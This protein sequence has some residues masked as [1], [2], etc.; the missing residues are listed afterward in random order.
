MDNDICKEIICKGERLIL[1]SLKAVFWPAQKALVLAD[2]HLG[3]SA[4]FRNNGIAIP[5]TVML[6]DLKRLSQLLNIF[7]PKKMIVTGDMF[8]HKVNADIKLF[9]EWRQQNG[10]L[11]IDL[12]PGNHDKLL[13]IDYED[14]QINLTES[15]YLIAPFTFVHEPATPEPGHFII[16]GHLHPGYVMGGRARQVMRLPC[17]I[18]N[19]SQ[20]ILPA[21]SAF[22][23]LCTGYETT[24]DN[25]YFVVGGSK[26]FCV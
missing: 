13:N 16:S 3:K 11:A 14:L 2:M 21:F 23:G 1:S 5:S 22:T 20:L 18:K 10:S 15:E 19:S 9:S 17:F 24:D 12:V 6:D 8:H 7:S 26:I 25:N 4:Y